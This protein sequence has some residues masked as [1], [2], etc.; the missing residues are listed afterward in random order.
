MR[1]KPAAQVKRQATSKVERNRL[2]FPGALRWP[3]CSMD[4]SSGKLKAQSAQVPIRTS[5]A[6]MRGL[7]KSRNAARTAAFHGI[8]K[9]LGED[10][11]V[12][13]VVLS[14]IQPTSSSDLGS[15]AGIT[16]PSEM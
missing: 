3:S 11:W 13:T 15:L 16:P 9:G 6:V 2:E 12:D 8:R 4:L 5:E 10:Y 1:N 14:A 7:M